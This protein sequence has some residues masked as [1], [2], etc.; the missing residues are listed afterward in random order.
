MRDHSGSASD[1][2][3]VSAVVSYVLVLGI[4]AILTSTLVVSFTPF[5]TNQQHD[6]TH[7]T[8]TV[9]GNDIA[10]DIDSVDRLAQTTGPSGT[11]EFRTRLPDRVGGSLYEINIEQQDSTG[12]YAITLRTADPDVST[13]VM[14]RTRTAIQE[15]TGADALDGGDLVFTEEEH[16]DS[17]TLVIENA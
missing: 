2:R 12:L 3:G 11:V 10:G 7:S 8:L 13:T 14:V 1:E 17:E 4:V 6:T 16:E 9:I 15:R 5:V